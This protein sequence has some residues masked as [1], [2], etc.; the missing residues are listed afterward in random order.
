HDGRLRARIPARR[1]TG[2]DFASTND[3][4]VSEGAAFSR[5]EIREAGASLTTTERAHPHAGELFDEFAFTSDHQHWVGT[6]MDGTRLRVGRRGSAEGV[7]EIGQG[8]MHHTLCLSPDGELALT[9]RYD[10]PAVQ[11]LRV[12]DGRRVFALENQGAIC[13][14]FSPDGRWIATAGRRTQLWRVG[15][16]SLVADLGGAPAVWPDQVPAFSTDGRWL[17]Y[18]AGAQLVRLVTVPSGEPVADLEL[19]GDDAVHGLIFNPAG[20]QLAVTR[21]HGVTAVWE[22]T[23]LNEAL[24]AAGLSGL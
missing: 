9:G 6:T 2:L 10:Q 7:R 5:W 16:W 13:G 17:A 14:A 20:D 4:Y 22:L 1:V 15:D 21:D 12:A 18:C 23:A 19:P 24:A 8:L 11:V 3:L